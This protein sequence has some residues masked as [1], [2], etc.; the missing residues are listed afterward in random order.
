MTDFSVMH[1]IETLST[2]K[3]AAI[4]SIGAV[5]FNS[6]GIIDEFYVNIDPKS[7]HM[8]GLHI[9]NDTVKWWKEQKAEAYEALKKDRRSLEDALTAYTEWYGNKSVWT[10]GNG[11]EFDNVIIE[12]A[13]GA[14]NRPTPW[15]YWDSMCY[16]T[17]VNLTNSRIT[18]SEDRVGVHHNALDDAKS[19]AL[20]LLKV[21]NR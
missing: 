2:K 13:Y 9:S 7:S 16:R 1:D 20:N 15:K 18:K 12:N 19:Q 3:N 11:A 10:W 8:A 17:V 21:L 4:L 6:T 5:K 14:L